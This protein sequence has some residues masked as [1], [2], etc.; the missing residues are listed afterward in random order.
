MKEKIL[1]SAMVLFAL[2]LVLAWGAC[3]GDNG[4]E[5]DTDADQEVL[6]DLTDTDVEV[7]PDPQPD[8]VTPDPQPDEVEDPV[9]DEVEDTTDMVEEEAEEHVT[10]ELICETQ[11][12]LVCDY[13]D[14]CCTTEEQATLTAI[15][16]IMGIDCTNVTGSSAYSQCLAEYNDSIDNDRMEI[17]D[18][19]EE[20]E[21]C[22]DALQ[23]GAAECPNFGNTQK[24]M[25]RTINEHCTGL[26]NGLVDNGGSC[27]LQTDCVT[28]HYCDRP[29]PDNPG[30]C[31][32]IVDTG[33]DCTRN[34]QCGLLA[35]CIDGAC[36]DFGGDGADCDEADLANDCDIGFWCDGGT[37]TAMLG[38]GED[39]TDLSFACDGLCS[40]TTSTCLDLCDGI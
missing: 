17:V 21:A 27:M 30:T 10:A 32:P 39:C 19:M 37:C 34:S 38:S 26:V 40:P 6:P 3:N 23:S 8:E 36:A 4:G 22:R 28:G 11:I 16:A 25:A 18:D 24:I 20:A 31:A 14:S 13:R 35:T 7:Q 5:E 33:G 2:P 12:Q 9:E 15:L 29:D 1:K